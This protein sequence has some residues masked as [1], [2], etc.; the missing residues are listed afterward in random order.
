MAFTFLGKEFV[1]PLD[2]GAILASTVMLPETSLE[3][4]V[5]MGTR[6][7]KIFLSFPEVVS[8][9]RTTGTA[10]ASEH[11]HP[12][13]H[14]HY[15]IELLPREKRKRGFRGDHRRRCARSSTT[16]PAWPTSSSSPSPTSWPRC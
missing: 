10:E 9:S 4:S 8:V 16:C 1:P 14:S 13:N 6:V 3:E 11:V 5:E 7:E 12:V 15:N 2:E